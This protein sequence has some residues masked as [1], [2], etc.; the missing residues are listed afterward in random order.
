[1][2]ASGACSLSQFGRSSRRS[3]IGIV[4]ALGAVRRASSGGIS[5][6]ARSSSC[7]IGHGVTATSYCDKALQCLRYAVAGMPPRPLQSHTARAIGAFV[8]E[9]GMLASGRKRRPRIRRGCAYRHGWGGL[10]RSRIRSL[11]R[12][13]FE[14]RCKPGSKQAACCARSNGRLDRR[15]VGQ[16]QAGPAVGETRSARS[17]Q[18]HQTSMTP[19]CY[20]NGTQASGASVV[21]SFAL[22]P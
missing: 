1:M 11:T 2:R 9:A 10:L 21:R 17:R 22:R 18:R 16:G 6:G 7:R 5:G 19:D 14:I 20:P 12:G 4:A 13:Q 8:P 15:K 3:L